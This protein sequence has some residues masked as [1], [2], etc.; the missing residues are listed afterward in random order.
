MRHR[1]GVF[2]GEIRIRRNEAGATVLI[3]SMP[4]PEAI[5]PLCN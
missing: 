1:I 3:A 2:D 5:I 4:L